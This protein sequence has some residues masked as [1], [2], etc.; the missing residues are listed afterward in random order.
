MSYSSGVTHT[1]IKDAGAVFPPLRSLAIV[2]SHPDSREKA[3]FD[4]PNYEIF[5]FN[6]A[7]Q[8]TEIYKRWDTSLQ[9]H[10]PEVYTSE[11]NWV[12]KDHWKWLQQDHGPDKRIFMQE[13]DPRVPNSVRYPIE[14]VRSLVPYQYLRSSPAL[15]LALA[16]YLG[17]KDIELYG[18]DLSSN[19]E[20]HYQAV[21][22]AFWIGFAHGHGVNLD[23][24]CWRSEFYEQPIYGYEGELQLDND[25]FEEVHREHEIVW[26]IKN[27]ACKKLQSRLDDAILNNKFD[28]A[29]DLSLTLETAMVNTA[30]QLWS[31]KEAE[32]YAERT[33]HVSRQ[34]FERVSAQA[35]LDGE[36]SKTSMDHSAGKCEY[37]WNI[38]KQH[39][40]LEA[41]NQF[42]TFLKEKNEHAESVGKN[43]GIFRSNLMFM[44][45]YDARVTAAG[46][47]RAVAQTLGDKS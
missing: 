29:A 31:M 27:N 39:G 4:D 22:Y 34:E 16:I 18:S 45:E 21:N 28:K 25:F 12:N 5:L 46:G 36:D 42:R 14:G 15:A 43:L 19:T 13:A 40:V 9:I 33:D 38:W 23:M 17:Y 35:Q 2:G 26:K 20:Y 6:E 44:N 1:E 3:P 37:V 7:P 10:K 32:R 41:K 47:Q 11:T 30:E 24:Q 8:K